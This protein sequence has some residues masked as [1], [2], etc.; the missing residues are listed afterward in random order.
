MLGFI[1]DAWG[2]CETLTGV[3]EQNRE[4]LWGALIGLCGQNNASLM[5]RFSP[6]V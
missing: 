5:V 6:D 4:V 1:A 2:L 3:C